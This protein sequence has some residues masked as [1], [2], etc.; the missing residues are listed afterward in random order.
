MLA[1]LQGLTIVASIGA[2]ICAGM[3][4]YYSMQAARAQRVADAALGRL[5]DAIAKMQ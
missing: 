3:A 5:R 1:A 2:I 4:V